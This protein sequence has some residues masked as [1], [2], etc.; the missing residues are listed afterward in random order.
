MEEARVLRDAGEF[1]KA[2]RRL[3]RVADSDDRYPGLWELAAQVYERLGEPD[4]AAECRR[5]AKE[6]SL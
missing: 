1:E 3:D 4:A 2:L 5:R 6:S